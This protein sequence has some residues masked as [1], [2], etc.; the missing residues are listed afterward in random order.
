MGSWE[1]ESLG[2]F[3]MYFLSCPLISIPIRKVVLSSKRVEL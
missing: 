1:K 3:L 2:Y